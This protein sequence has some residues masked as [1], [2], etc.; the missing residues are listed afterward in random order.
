MNNRFFIGKTENGYLEHTL[1]ERRGYTSEAL[2]IRRCMGFPL[3][4]IVP[5]E[6]K[7]VG[8]TAEEELAPKRM[9]KLPTKQVLKEALQELVSSSTNYP[10]Q[11]EVVLALRTLISLSSRLDELELA[12][13]SEIDRLD[14]R[15][16][17]QAIIA[18][19]KD[20]M[21]PRKRVEGGNID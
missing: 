17:A 20:L 8:E 15:L 12:A 1:T 19:F 10:L 4:S 2:C 14:E 6:L 5:V 21:R 18:D 7:E 13:E 11:D 9:P 16:N 3:A